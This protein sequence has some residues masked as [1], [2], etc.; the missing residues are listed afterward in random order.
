MFQQKA[1]LDSALRQ[2]P[3]AADGVSDRA[4]QT[5]RWLGENFDAP[6]VSAGHARAPL[7]T[8]EDFLDG[9]EFK[10]H[11]FAQPDLP[12][13]T[14]T[15]TCA[16][17]FIGRYVYF[18]ALPLAALHLRDGLRVDIDGRSLLI[19][20]EQVVLG[21]TEQGRE[22]LVPHL[23]FTGAFSFCR[24]LSGLRLA[25]ERHL[26]PLVRHLKAETRLAS[27]AQWR[28]AGD[29][30]AFA[31]MAVGEKLGKS[32]AARDAATALLKH[33]ASPL[34]NPQ[35]H[36]VSIPV[37]GHAEPKSCVARGGCC[38]YYKVDGGGLCANCILQT[39]ENR[40]ARLTELAV[41]RA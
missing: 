35:M 13:G 23:R 10:A 39:E 22:L 32:A 29:S 4:G 30:I 16:A 18:L 24:E 1:T 38:R 11:L 9:G 28:L 40:L 7:A 21:H 8:Y 19:G 34:S 3:L 25:I 2:K 17:F 37:P 33:P 15:R 14:D 41:S 6:I 27:A 5:I 20:F 12:D 31:F 26:E 36:F